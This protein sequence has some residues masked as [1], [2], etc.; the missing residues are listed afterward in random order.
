MNYSIH[1]LDGS[2]FLGGE[3]QDSHWNEMPDKPI[4]ELIY[5]IYNKTIILKGYEAY[6]HIVNYQY[7]L[8]SKENTTTH[9]ILMGLHKN[10]VYRFFIDFKRNTI[11]SDKV[12]MGK[13]LNNSITTGWK[14]G[15]VDS[16]PS[17]KII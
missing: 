11:Y 14:K 3:P 2:I 6:N 15:V 1:F 4:S 10:I 16:I 5:S 8:Q 12:P 9:I 13:E 7:N 17:Y